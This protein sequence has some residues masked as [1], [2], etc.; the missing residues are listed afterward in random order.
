MEDWRRA[1][2]GEHTTHLPGEVIR[3]GGELTL[4]CRLAEV[5]IR[6]LH[7]LHLWRES[8]NKVNSD[9][10]GEHGDILP[11]KQVTAEKGKSWQKVLRI[12]HHF[13]NVLLTKQIMYYWG[14]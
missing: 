2:E 1:T 11:S 14:R 9:K 5:L 6:P 12:D 10:I 3:H 4:R 8:K 13:L 7:W